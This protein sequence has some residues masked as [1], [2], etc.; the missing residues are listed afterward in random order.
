MIM[1]RRKKKKHIGLL[2]VTGVLVIGAGTL[3]LCRDTII[4]GVKTKA[5]AEIG[6]KL[7]ES[8]IGGSLN[9]AGQKVDISEIMEQM[10]QAD[11][12]KVTEIAEKYI[13]PDNIQE[14][15]GLAASGDM[16]GLKDMAQEQLTQE[17]KEELQRMYEKYKG[18]IQVP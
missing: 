5:A 16:E 15:A 11:V 17:D 14:A 9:I 4:S 13:S 7:L 6:K 8:Q 1:G 2:V 3:F 12:E 10:E 18:Q